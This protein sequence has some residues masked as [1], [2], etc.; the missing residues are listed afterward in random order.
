MNGVL[1]KNACNSELLEQNGWTEYE[2]FDN[3]VE[4]KQA[5]VTPDMVLDVKDD[6]F[7]SRKAFVQLLQDALISIRE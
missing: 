7:V 6:G 5:E 2:Y 4:H 3:G 1:K